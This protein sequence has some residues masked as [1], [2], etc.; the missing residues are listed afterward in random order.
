MT[1][2]LEVSK[3]KPPKKVEVRIAVAL[4]KILLNRDFFP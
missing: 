4:I 2:Y 1:I 3:D